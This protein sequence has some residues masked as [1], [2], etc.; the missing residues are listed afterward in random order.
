MHLKGVQMIPSQFFILLSVVYI[1]PS[2][3]PGARVILSGVCLALAVAALLWD[4]FK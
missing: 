4:L 2:V 3:S 1:A